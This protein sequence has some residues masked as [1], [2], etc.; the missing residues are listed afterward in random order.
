MSWWTNLLGKSFPLSGP[1]FLPE[2]QV[3]AGTFQP[4]QCRFSDSMSFLCS[5]TLTHF[6]QD[7]GQ[8]SSPVAQG[9]LLSDSVHP[10]SRLL[11]SP[12]SPMTGLFIYIQLTC[13]ATPSISSLRVLLDYLS[14]KYFSSNAY[15][16]C[17]VLSSS[18][19][20]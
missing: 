4:R 16:L 10:F 15:G 12:T 7:Q 5:R 9:L 3:E 11:S 2:S 13:E 6:L 17:C 8:S 1:L 20:L 18:H 19:S 14:G